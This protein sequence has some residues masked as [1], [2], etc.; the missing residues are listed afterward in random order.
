[1]ARPMNIAS[2]TPVNRIVL[3]G[4][5]NLTMS[6]P[7]VIKTAQRVCGGPNQFLI[8]TGHGRSYGVYSRVLFRGLPGIIECGLWD[9]LAKSPGLPTFALLTDLGNDIGYEQPPDRL[10]GWVCWC[11]DRLA[12]REARIIVTALPVPSLELLSS[13]QY[14]FFRTLLFPD[15]NLSWEQALS[16]VRVVDQALREFC[17]G[18]DVAFIEQRREWYGTDPVHIRR[19]QRP[20]AYLEILKPWL[21]PGREAPPIVKTGLR[22][23]WRLRL[24]TSQSRCLF[25]FEQ[26][27]NQPCGMLPDGSTIS[28]Y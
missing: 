24:L 3:L 1:M 17:S 19:H 9:D 10:M 5:S 7:I 26:H 25:G 15:L 13:S 14:R 21:E 18:Q 8:A 22:D 11:L 28:L 6:L 20:G 4:A 27:R 2:P 12:E 23:R 16:R